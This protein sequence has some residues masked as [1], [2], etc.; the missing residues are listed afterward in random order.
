MHWPPSKKK[1]SSTNSSTVLVSSQ[2]EYFIRQAEEISMYELWGQENNKSC[3]AAV[4]WL[5]LEAM[6]EDRFWQSSN[7]KVTT[8]KFEKLR[9]QYHL[10]EG[11]V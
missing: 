5:P 10:R 3:E 9:R 1:I 11:F 8:P 7:I 6:Y 4:L 2:S